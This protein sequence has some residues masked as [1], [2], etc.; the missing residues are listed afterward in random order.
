MVRRRRQG[1]ALLSGQLPLLLPTAQ[2]QR[3]Q[4]Q[5]RQRQRQKRV[6]QLHEHSK[7]PKRVNHG[8]LRAAA[9]CY[10]HWQRTARGSRDTALISASLSPRFQQQ[11]IEDFFKCA[12]DAKQSKLDSDVRHQASLTI[13]PAPIFQALLQSSKLCVQT[14]KS[15]DRG[16]KKKWNL[17]NSS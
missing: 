15:T 5:Q 3:T 7:L 16:R 2:K 1:S 10:Q 4:I 13:L 14:S 6:R 8:W 9:G 11:R 17:R 12:C